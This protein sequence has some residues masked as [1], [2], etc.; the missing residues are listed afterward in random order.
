MHPYT[1]NELL[2]EP[3]LDYVINMDSYYGSEGNYTDYFE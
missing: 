1:I 2:N 3:F